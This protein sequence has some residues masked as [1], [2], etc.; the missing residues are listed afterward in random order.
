MSEDY[1][2][3]RA[4]KD[5]ILAK[6]RVRVIHILPVGDRVHD[7]LLTCWCHPML[8]LAGS[9]GVVIHNAHDCR[10][11][12]ERQGCKSRPWLLVGAEVSSAAI[13]KAKGQP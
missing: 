3:L 13:S 2:K 11:K 8:E 7:A 12:L 1:E 5:A 6:Q 4:Q 10:E 9:S